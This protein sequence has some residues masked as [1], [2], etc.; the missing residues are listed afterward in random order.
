MQQKQQK[1]DFKKV[2]IIEGQWK[3]NYIDG[4]GRII[5]QK[6]NCY[7]G[8]FKKGYRSGFGQFFWAN[9]DIFQGYF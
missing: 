6:G 8:E 5:D 1:K 3:N 9:G 7:I 2:T 4:Y